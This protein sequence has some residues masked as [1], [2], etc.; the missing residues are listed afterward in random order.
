MANACLCRRPTFSTWWLIQASAIPGTTGP[1][2]EIHRS[3]CHGRPRFV[4]GSRTHTF[5]PHGCNVREHDSVLEDY[6]QSIQEHGIVQHCRGSMFATL[7]LKISRDNQGH[8]TYEETLPL[9]LLSWGSLSRSFYMAELE[10]PSNPNIIASLAEGID[11]I[12]VLRA[13]LPEDAQYFV[14]DYHNIW[15]FCLDTACL[16]PG[17]AACRTEGRPSPPIFEG[18]SQVQLP[19][20]WRPQSFRPLLIRRP[21]F[22]NREL[23]K[24]LFDIASPWG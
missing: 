8:E 4:H 17:C 12:C 24:L 22:L 2:L 19:R 14:K 10:D 20:G 5:E 16:C 21:L 9:R 3:R 18:G 7:T 13:R 23:R 15:H 6:K 1:I 11:N